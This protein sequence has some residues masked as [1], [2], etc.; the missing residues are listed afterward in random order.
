MDGGRSLKPGAGVEAGSD[1]AEPGVIAAE[2][3]AD[4]DPE[5]DPDPEEPG[6]DRGEDPGDDAGDARL[7]RG[8]DPGW[9]AAG[10]GDAPDV[11]VAD[12]GSG[13]MAF[14]GA[15]IIPGAGAATDDPGLLPVLSPAVMIPLLSALLIR[16]LLLSS[17]L[18]LLLVML[19][20]LLSLLP[21][22]MVLLMPGAACRLSITVPLSP[23]ASAGAGAS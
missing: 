11:I 5:A 10:D 17:E 14:A 6:E 1:S 13:A 9:G 21:P 16:L 22:A 18:S 15:A 23:G 19:L 7:R 12:A 2:A 4:A 20:L 8:A 3:G